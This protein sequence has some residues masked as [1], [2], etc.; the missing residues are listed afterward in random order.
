MLVDLRALPDAMDDVLAQRE[1]IAAI[2]QRHAPSRRY[3]TVV[4]NGLNRIAAN[5]LRIKLS[6]L[7]YRSISSATSPKTRS[8]ST[9]APSR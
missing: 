8:T 7:C 5:E 2:A 6:E 3:W 9:S 1:A 4:G